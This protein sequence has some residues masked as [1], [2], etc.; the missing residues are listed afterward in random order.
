MAIQYNESTKTFKLDAGS[1]SYV[2]HIY[3]ENYLVNLYY[4]GYIPDMDLT[5]YYPYGGIYT[6]FEPLRFGI[7]KPFSMDSDP[8]EYPSFGTGDFRKTAIRI[9]A[10]EG[11]S[12]TDLRYVSHV[13]YSGKPEI[14]GLPATYANT[15][16]E[17]QTLEITTA[18][19]VTGAEVVLIYTAF[20][21]QNVI[22]RSVRVKNAGKKPFV[23][24]DLCSAFVNLPDM[25]YTMTTLYGRHA[26]E[27][28][29]SRTPLAHGMQSIVSRRGATGH[30]YNNFMA[31]S[32]I[33]SDE[34]HGD[35]YGFNFVY[36]GSF[37]MGVEVSYHET[38]SVFVGFNPEQ[39]SWKLAPGEVFHAPETVMVYTDGGVGEMSRIF[40]RFYNNN[41][42]RGRYKTEKRP[43]LIN[44]WEAAYFDFDEEK[45]VNFA[46]HAKDLGIEMLV[47]DDG[48]FGH[49]DDD[50]TSLGDWFVNEKKINLKSLT[51]RV[52][53]M[54]LK[55]GIWY[56][57]EMI[58]EDS[59]LFRAH[60][61]WCIH[62]EGREHTNCRQQYV[63]DMS[64]DEV[65]DHI[66]EQMHKVLSE[67]RIDYVK[68]DFNRNLT[69]VGSAGLT[70]E[71]HPEMYHRFMLGTYKL[72]DRL[73]KAHPDILLENC[74]GGGGRFDPGMLYYSPQIWCSDN[75]DPIDRLSIQFGTSLCYPAS[76]MGAHVS[77]CQRTDYHTKGNV[78]LWG[79]FG[80]ELDPNEL[81]PEEREIVKQQ[82]KDYHKYYD[83]IHYG[84]LYRLLYPNDKGANNSPASRCAW[85]LVSQD[86]TEAL[87]T[88][89]MMRHT[90]DPRFVLRLKGLD[91]EKKYRVDDS[92]LVLSGALLMKGGINL[93]RRPHDTND[94]YRI[95]LKE[96]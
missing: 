60:P 28:R 49:R 90:M 65:V 1:S 91:P 61:D 55:F 34:D 21:K 77:L 3:D 81:K 69:E 80:Y 7:P 46:E 11:S 57:P 16:D 30:S 12:A 96:V 64:R 84:D 17:A 93:T 43:L 68:W 14:P 53:N 20:E 71:Q 33:G 63:I 66:F 51:E 38:S 48:W 73:M 35:T 56:E 59:E 50:T 13:I 37:H 86:K 70:A 85:Q 22:T 54:G 74:S 95:Y 76:T 5:S 52:Q 67:N 6:S 78:A 47:M 2:I 10:H 26:D 79:T 19:S 36:S 32:R 40:H 72:M 18:D 29:I 87:V 58:S 15:V 83:L 42:V 25:D 23:I 27:R 88:V 41:L 94:S 45:L 82:V 62:V 92:D 4:G 39:F 24:E 89:V 44:S 9:R 31:L 75:T 8:L